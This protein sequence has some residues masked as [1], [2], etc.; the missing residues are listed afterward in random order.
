[1]TAEEYKS[2]IRTIRVSK[3]LG[4]HFLINEDVARAEARYAEGRRALEMGPGLGILTRALCSVA[5]S[6]VAVERDRALY[7]MLVQ[8]MDAPNLELIN[9]DFFDVGYDRL[10]GADIMVANIPYNLSSKTIGWLADRGMEAVLCLQK[11]FVEHMLAE[12]DTRDYS[13]LS[14]IAHLQF[15]VS[16]VLDV[17]LNDFYPVPNV[18]SVVAH[19]KPKKRLMRPELIAIIGAIMSHKKKKVRN[20]VVD[21]EKALS[22]SREDARRLSDAVPFSNERLFKLDP[23]KIMEIAESIADRWQY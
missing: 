10:G 5:K 23:A 16:R 8:N 17:P 15:D 3:K 7:E 20:A 18:D 1:M 19:I 21:A 12:P 11:E 4:Q 6:V 14:V 2:I 9:A 22:L 13:K